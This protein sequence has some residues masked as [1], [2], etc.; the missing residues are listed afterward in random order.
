MKR[1]VSYSGAWLRVAAVFLAATA[2]AAAQMGGGMMGFG[3]PGAPGNPGQGLGAGMGDAM[4]GAMNLGMGGR[5]MMDGP[6]IGPDG[7]AYVLR[8]V[9][10]TSTTAANVTTAQWKYELMAVNVRDGAPR[11]KLEL[12]AG[13][14]SAP[15]LGRDGRIFLTESDHR[16]GGDNA[17]GRMNLATAAATTKAKLLVIT[18]TQTS[19]PVAA[20]TEVEANV[21][22][23]LTVASDEAN[24]YVV[25]ATGHDRG[26][27]TAGTGGQ[28]TVTAGEKYLYAFNPDGR[29][30]FRLKLSQARV[31]VPA[32]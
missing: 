21:L 14:L 16:F 2:I 5:E 6:T 13:M 32:N 29:V 20:T 4:L 7:T 9:S 19:A 27:V 31:G 8:A 24:S 22:S 26:T 18:A 3:N 11:W 15:L 25:Y 12:T 1:R 30:R 23:G 28:I 10:S 17:A